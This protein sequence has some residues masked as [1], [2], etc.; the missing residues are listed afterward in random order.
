MEDVTIENSPPATP[1]FEAGNDPQDP[2]RPEVEEEDS[3]PIPPIANPEQDVE[4]TGTNEVDRDE[5]PADNSDDDELSELDEAEFE[6]LRKRLHVLQQTVA[7]VDDTLYMD[8]LTRV[9]ATT[10][11]R[12]ST[13]DSPNWRDL[14]LALL[15]MHHFGELAIKNGGLYTKSKPSSEASSRLVEMMSTLVASDL[16][17][18]P[19]PA[20]QLQYMEICV[21]YEQFFEQNSRLIPKV[22]E[23]FVRL[24][25]HN[26]IKVRSR[27]WYLFHRFVKPLRAQLGNVSHDI[28]QAVMPQMSRR[29]SRRSFTRKRS[30]H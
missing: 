26:H 27:S 2:S 17:S 13:D 3:T 15:E 20:V 5:D 18:Y 24:T 25:H 4:A 12:L 14:D 19:H 8:T 7:A 10:L 21:R 29:A 1:G 16:A 9:V 6:D 23:N 22:L 30:Y 11:G 28:I